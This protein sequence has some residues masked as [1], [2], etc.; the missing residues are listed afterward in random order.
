MKH[1]YTLRKNSNTVF[2][3]VVLFGRMTVENGVKQSLT[4]DETFRVDLNLTLTF[5]VMFLNENPYF[6]RGFGKSGQFYVGI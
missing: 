4:L 2:V 5:K 1:N 6:C 3:R